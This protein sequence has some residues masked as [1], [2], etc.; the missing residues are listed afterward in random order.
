MSKR[1]AGDPAPSAADKAVAIAL[2]M[3]EA[4]SRLE[5]TVQKQRELEARRKESAAEIRRLERD[6]RRLAPGAV[7]R[8]TPRGGAGKRIVAYLARCPNG[9]SSKQIADALASALPRSTVRDRLS[10]L[11]KPGGPVEATPTR[12]GSIYSLR[13]PAAAPATVRRRAAP[14]PA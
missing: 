1:K 2:R 3:S 12:G 11:V 6:L 5:E 13:Q 7:S 8:P 4:R 14:P 9:A 10:R